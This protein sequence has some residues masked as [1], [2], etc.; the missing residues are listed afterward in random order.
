[1][2]DTDDDP[3]S[4]DEAATIGFKIVEMADR[5]KVADKCLPGSQAKWCFE[6][7]DVKYDVVVTVRRDG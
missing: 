5:V 3:V 1:M 6:M 2:A 7:S 4:Y